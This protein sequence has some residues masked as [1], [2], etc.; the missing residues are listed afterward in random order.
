MGQKSKKATDLRDSDPPGN[1]LD[2]SNQIFAHAKNNLRLV[3]F[4]KEV[5]RLLIAYMDCDVIRMVFRERNL[6][7]RCEIDNL[8]DQNFRFEATPYFQDERAYMVWSSGNNKALEDI[9]GKVTSKSMDSSQ[10]WVS[11]NG[12]FWTNDLSS[13]TDIGLH[14]TDSD[15]G[16]EIKIDGATKSMALVPVFAGN[17]CIG[18]L[19]I[20]SYEKGFFSDAILDSCERITQTLGMALLQRRLQAALRERIKE[21]TCLLGIA[22]LTAQAGISMDEVLQKVVELLPPAWLYSDVTSARIVLNNHTYRTSGYRKP[23]QNIK[24]DIVGE[25]RRYGFIEVG[26]VW[27]RPLLDEGPFLIEERNLL[28]G[29]AH[30]ISNTIEQRHSEEEKRKL[31]EQLRHAD[32]L[33]TIGQLSAGL[34]HELNEPLANILG[35]AQLAVNDKE[36]TAQTHKDLE[37]IISAALHARVVIS[38]LLVFAKQTS[39]EKTRVDINAVIEDGLHFLR[40][41][42]VKGGI[43]LI[44]NLD[45]NISTVEVDNSQILQVM[46]NLVVNSIQ[47]MPEG[48]RLKISTTQRPDAIMLIVEDTGSGMSDEVKKN[49]FIPFFT[50]KDVNEGTGLGLSVVHGIVTSHG[51]TIDFESEPGR[52]TKFI[53]TLPVDAKTSSEEKSD[54]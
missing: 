23:V 1:I 2:L 21:L 30:E 41:R 9:C 4:L 11:S 39:S 15:G 20:S 42:C 44:L 51:G 14:E 52:G 50:T 13:L 38:K 27:E 35:F 46:T 19:Q 31:Q 8:S 5:F 22:K 32:R 28:D 24:A 43:E 45:N 6:R 40:S 3:K 33:A 34:A 36:V 17:E 26:Y 48:G 49:I 7:C 54:G 25:K 12:S 16:P 47:A 37:K 53:I 29:I 18:L 10:P